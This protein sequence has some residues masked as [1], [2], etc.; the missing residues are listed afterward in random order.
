MSLI[1]SKQKLIPLRTVAKMLA[2]DPKDKKEIHR[3]AYG[4]SGNRKRYEG[5]VVA[6]HNGS[7]W[8]TENSLNQFLREQEIIAEN[9][10]KNFKKWR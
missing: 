1:N 10:E 2:F 6:R 3:I 8:V 4:I 5:I 9:A 7:V